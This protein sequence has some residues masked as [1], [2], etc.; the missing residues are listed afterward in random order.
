VKKWLGGDKSR[1]A[2]R[3][4]NGDG[5]CYVLGYPRGD[6]EEME[7]F[8]EAEIAGIFARELECISQGAY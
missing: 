1:V 8:M 5:Y 7:I 4:V 3:S 6:N 2:S